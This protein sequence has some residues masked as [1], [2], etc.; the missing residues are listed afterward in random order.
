MTTTA[1]GAPAGTTET[2]GEAQGPAASWSGV[3]ALSVCAFALIASEFLPVSLLTPMATDL[4]VSEGMTGQGIA[5][6]GA[7]AVFTSLFI[8][9]LAGSLD[10]KTLLLGLTA[11]MGLSGAVIALAPNYVIYMVGRALIGVVVGWWMMD[12]LDEATFKPLIG[13]IILGLTLTQIARLWRP[14]LFDHVPHKVWFAWM[15]GLLAGVTTMLA[16]AA[17]P[18]VALYL[19]AVSLPKYQLIGTSAWFF[20][21]L[22]VLKLPF[23]ASLG[24][25]D[26]GTLALNAA[27]TPAVALGMAGGRWLVQRVPQRIFDSVLLVLTAVVALRLIGV[28]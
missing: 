5:I 12:Y 1:I 24:L 19:L 18:I 20:F 10:R 7:F 27:F 3:F 4:R 21:V 23:S 9:V 17:G 2:Q 15:L 25:I 6:S 26:V 14:R 22:N 16:N 11:A 28:F 8:S 13:V